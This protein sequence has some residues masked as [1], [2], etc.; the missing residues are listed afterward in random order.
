MT[1]RPKRA[2]L[3]VN[4]DLYPDLELPSGYREIWEKP[5]C[6]GD[7][8][9][10]IDGPFDCSL[11]DGARVTAE[12]SQCTAPHRHLKWQWKCDGEACGEPIEMPWL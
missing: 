5:L 3:E 2:R 1:D 11:P 6:D 8:E 9:M 12:I 10:L 4:L 7:V